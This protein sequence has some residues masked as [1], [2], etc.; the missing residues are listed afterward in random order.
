[1]ARSERLTSGSSSPLI[2]LSHLIT[3]VTYAA[4]NT[5][6]LCRVRFSVLFPKAATGPFKSGTKKMRIRLN[7]VNTSPAPL[8]N[9]FTSPAS[10]LNPRIFPA[11]SITSRAPPKPD[12]LQPH[13]RGSHA[14][15]AKYEADG[16]SIH[17][18]LTLLF[19]AKYTKGFT[20]GLG[21]ESLSFSQHYPP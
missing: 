21:M 7:N 17:P 8:S 6:I 13:Q 12:S 1:M 4:S 16:N 20:T 18:H 10:G 2:R 19:H 3:Q 5:S 9:Q 15:E 11:P 14:L